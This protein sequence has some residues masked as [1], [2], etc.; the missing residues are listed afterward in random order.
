MRIRPAIID[1]STSI[2]Q[3]VRAAYRPYLARLPQ[4]P[5]PLAVDYRCAVANGGIFVAVIEDTIRGLVAVRASGPCFWLDNVAV[6]P[7]AQGCGIG[8][9]LIGYAETLARRAGHDH[10]HLYTHA[11]MTENQA[12]YASL[13]FIETERGRE[14]GRDRVFMH[15]PLAARSGD[16]LSP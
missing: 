5:A 15:K 9:A 14:H 3:V 6:D 16:N 13:G 11:L 10:I 8:R 4:P 2:G 1:D 7:V 12:L